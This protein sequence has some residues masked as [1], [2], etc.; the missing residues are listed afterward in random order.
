M[1]SPFRV[2]FQHLK[3]TKPISQNSMSIFHFRCLHA[4]ELYTRKSLLWESNPKILWCYNVL[5]IKFLCLRSKL[6]F[7]WLGS[8]MRS[9]ATQSTSS[10]RRN[11]QLSHTIWII[12]K[13]KAVTFFYARLVFESVKAI[14]LVLVVL[15]FD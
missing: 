4:L 13:M 10:W 1:N 15:F 5:T 3:F 11:L 9:R 8:L 12:V 2:L 6:D 7:R 14:I